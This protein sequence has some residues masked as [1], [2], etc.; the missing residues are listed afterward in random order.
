[1][2]PAIAAFFLQVVNQL[3]SGAAPP[4]STGR[5]FIQEVTFVPCSE[6]VVIPL[7]VSSIFWSL[8]AVT[9]RTP[10]VV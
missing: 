1:M 6:V 5:V 4:A 8:I 10:D 7:F 3:I 9:K 2:I